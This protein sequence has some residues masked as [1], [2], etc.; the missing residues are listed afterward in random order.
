[1]RFRKSRPKCSPTDFL[2]KLILN[3]YRGKMLLLLLWKNATSVIFKTMPKVNNRLR[4]EN[5]PNLVT[6]IE[7]L[8]IVDAPVTFKSCNK[9]VAAFAA[10]QDNLLVGK[11]SSPRSNQ[12]YVLQIRL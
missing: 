2:S 1:M 5:S 4:G 12:T 6:L 9:C 10:I 7:T 3:W 8:K 11:K